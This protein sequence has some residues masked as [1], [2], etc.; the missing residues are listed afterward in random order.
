MIMNNAVNNFFG[1]PSP[2]IASTA[3]LICFD[4][5][6]FIKKTNPQDQEPV[7]PYTFLFLNLNDE[8][9]DIHQISYLQ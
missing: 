3:I 4:I 2:P 8:I 6:L 7:F 9:I 1:E 5:C